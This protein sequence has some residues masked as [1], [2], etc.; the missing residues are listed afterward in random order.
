LHYSDNTAIGGVYEINVSAT[1]IAGTTTV[2]DT[3]FVGCGALVTANTWGKFMCHNLGADQSLDAFTPAQGINGDYYQYG[4]KLPVKTMADDG[5]NDAE[6]G[7]SWGTSALTPQC[8]GDGST[9]TNVTTK[10]ATYDPCPTGYRVP[11]YDEW[12]YLRQNNTKSN[13]GTWSSG[14]WS[15]S[16]FGNSLYLPAA[17]YRYYS[18]GVLYYRGTYGFYW[19]TRS[20]SSNTNA[21]GFLFYSSD[22]DMYNTSRRYGMSVRCVAE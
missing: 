4:G 6:N 1:N 14:N 20:H 22:T 3:I 19:S 8:Y 15:G 2:K 13:F 12:D 21:Y 5:N 17:G 11:S 10:N 9:G 7:Y 18:S 16:T